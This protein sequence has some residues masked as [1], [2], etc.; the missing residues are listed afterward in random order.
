MAPPLKGDKIIRE[1]NQAHKDYLLNY[2]YLHDY[3]L[4]LEQIDQMIADRNGLCDI[5]HLPN[6]DNTRLHVDHDHDTG[7]VRG[8]LCGN[9]NR[10]IGNFGHYPDRLRAAADYLDF[11]YSL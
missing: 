4:T 9:C 2:H 11:W 3:G 5:C 10:G 8:M 6:Q 1:R 7:Q